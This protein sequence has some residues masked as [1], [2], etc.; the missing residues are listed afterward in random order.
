[1]FVLPKYFYKVSYLILKRIINLIQKLLDKARR[2]MRG[3]RP[4]NLEIIQENYIVENEYVEFMITNPDLLE[5]KEA[6]YH[7]YELISST[8][9]FY[10]ITDEKVMM[11]NRVDGEDETSLHENV[12]IDSSSEFNIYWDQVKDLIH[13]NSLK[14]SYSYDSI[15]IFRVRLW[16][17]GDLKNSHIRQTKSAIIVDNTKFVSPFSTSLTKGHQ[18]RLYHDFIKPLVRKAKVCKEFLTLDIETINQNGIQVPIVI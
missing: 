16:G 2:G 11:V 4:H 14:A 3:E 8:D 9:V 6:L 1:M 10:K 18:I 15:P 5:V 17:V 13:A 12:F 7:V